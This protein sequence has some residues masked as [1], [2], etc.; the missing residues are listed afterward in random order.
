MAGQGWTVLCANLRPGSATGWGVLHCLVSSRP[1]CS[2]LLCLQPG[3]MKQHRPS[4]AASCSLC[5]EFSH[6]TWGDHRIYWRLPSIPG[7]HGASRVALGNLLGLM[8]WGSLVVLASCG[9]NCATL[10]TLKDVGSL[11]K[12][13]IVTMRT[14]SW[15]VGAGREEGGIATTPGVLPALG[16]A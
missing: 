13:K 1:S 2:W 6:T 3:H 9:T 8:V 12:D 14:T 10:G 15:S 7:A 4:L 5:P 11:S 16:Q